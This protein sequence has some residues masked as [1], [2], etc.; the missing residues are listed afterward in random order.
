MDGDSLAA[1][2]EALERAEGS[3]EA[4]RLA[5]GLLESWYPETEPR[6]A[7]AKAFRATLRG[8]EGKHALGLLDKLRY[9]RAAIADYEGLVEAHPESLELRF[10]RYAFFSQLPIVFGVRRFVEPDRAA[11]LELLERKNDPMVP[12]AQREDMIAWLLA[13]GDLSGRDRERLLALSP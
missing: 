1:M 11:L 4:T 8:L 10:M 13:A 9:V 5:I 2:R 7:M 3:P 6:P 12:R